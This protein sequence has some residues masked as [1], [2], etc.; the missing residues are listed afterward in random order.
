[1]AR[2]DALGL[3]ELLSRLGGSAITYSSKCNPGSIS[4]GSGKELGSY[5]VEAIQESPL[6]HAVASISQQLRCQ[7]GR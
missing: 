6:I 4:I 5:L 1:M 7:L 3:L 2:E